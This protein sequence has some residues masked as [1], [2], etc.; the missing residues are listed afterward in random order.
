MKTALTVD[1]QIG[2]P[3]EIRRADHLGA[4]DLFSFDRLTPGHYLLTKLTPHA[5]RF[6]VAT[7]EDGLPVIRANGGVITAQ[8]V[9]EIESQTP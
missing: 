1:G 2:V 6:T 7:A 9:R 3:P 4:G 8:M 5:P